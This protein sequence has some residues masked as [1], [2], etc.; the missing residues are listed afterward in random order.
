MGWYEA[1]KDAITAAQKADNIP[2]LQQLLDMQREMQD[3]QQQNFEL[4]KRIAELEEEESHKVKYNELRSAVYEVTDEGDEIGPYCT[5]C[6]EVDKKLVSVHRA[7][8]CTQE[9]FYCSHCKSKMPNNKKNINI[10][11]YNGMI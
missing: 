8:T 10:P 5:R 2:L 3:M 4:K 1:A 9:Y 11:N 7:D 6:W